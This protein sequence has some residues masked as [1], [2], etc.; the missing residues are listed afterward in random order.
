MPATD[1][2]VDASS[3]LASAFCIFVHYVEKLYE[4]A[5]YH[6]KGHCFESEE[7]GGHKH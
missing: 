7:T 2:E 4:A 6:A 3:F 5:K 1:M